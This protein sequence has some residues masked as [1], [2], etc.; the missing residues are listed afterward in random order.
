MVLALCSVKPSPYQEATFGHPITKS[1]TKLHQLSHVAYRHLDHNVRKIFQ[2][3]TLPGFVYLPRSL[4]MLC[5][6]ETCLEIINSTDTY[7]YY[8]GP[9]LV[10]TN[11]SGYLQP[12]TS[13][14]PTRLLTTVGKTVTTGQ[15]NCK[16]II[17]DI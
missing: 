16:T 1:C 5:S 17:Y 4:A 13:T 3:F 11:Q 10:Y 8:D 6:F 12:A 9:L 2:D 15:N 7:I 14:K